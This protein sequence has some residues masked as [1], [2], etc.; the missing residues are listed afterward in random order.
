MPVFPNGFPPE[1]VAA[2]ERETGRRVLCNKPYSGTEVLKVFGREQSE[3]GALIV[4]TS[5]DSV[6]QIAAHID[7]IPLDE[8]Y[9]VCEKARKNH[10]GEILRRQSH[11]TSL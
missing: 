6:M 9:S 5:A 7:S 10:D 2:L 4:Y 11:S 1:I 3:T 8:L